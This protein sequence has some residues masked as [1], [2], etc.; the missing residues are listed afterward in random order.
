M[1]QLKVLKTKTSP[2]AQSQ[3]SGASETRLDSFG[4]HKRRSAGISSAGHG[5]APPPQHDSA[6]SGLLLVSSSLPVTH[7]RGFSLSLPHESQDKEGK[8]PDSP[9]ST[10]SKLQDLKGD[11]F[12][13][14][15]KKPSLEV[16]I[17]NS[18]EDPSTLSAFT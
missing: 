9:G 5:L 16:S 6:H 18:P 12:R 4:M 3:G 10:Q 14:K 8:Q 1:I 11:Y 7:H 17:F 15:S 13:N 2:K